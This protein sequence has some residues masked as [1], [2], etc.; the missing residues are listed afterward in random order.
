MDS[1]TSAVSS[2][3][4]KETLSNG[5]GAGREQKKQTYRAGGREKNRL[6]WGR[7]PKR[8]NELFIFVHDQNTQCSSWID[9]GK[10]TG[11]ALQKIP[12]NH[13]PTVLPKPGA[14][15]TWSGVN[16]LQDH[17]AA[18][19]VIPSD[20]HDGGWS[21]W[22][23]SAAQSACQT[24]WRRNL[25]RSWPGRPHRCT[26]WD[27]W[28]ESENKTKPCDEGDATEIY[29]V[30][31]SMWREKNGGN[32]GGNTQHINIRKSFWIRVFH[33]PTFNL[34]FPHCIHFWSPSEKVLLWTETALFSNLNNPQWQKKP[35]SIPFKQTY[36]RRKQASRKE[37]T[38]RAHKKSQLHFRKK[39]N[40]WNLV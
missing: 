38:E 11:C 3:N 40:T 14:P 22:W 26:T 35:I 30:G 29:L 36:R 16:R 21:R 37:C 13:L 7:K 20:E 9:E 39:Q 15:L 27:S 24:R 6:F 28:W 31:W 10:K 8:W 19:S 32:S 18:F 4:L 33:V 34:F 1:D 12:T 5:P 17:Y 23:T 2:A 25:C